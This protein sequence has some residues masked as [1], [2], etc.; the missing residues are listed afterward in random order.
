[1]TNSQC[2]V[3]DMMSRLGAME[4]KQGEGVVKDMKQGEREAVEKSTKLFLLSHQPQWRILE[5]LH[6][7]TLMSY[8]VHMVTNLRSYPSMHIEIP[9]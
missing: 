1:M 9:F 8:M 6:H 5:L 2:D 3:N 7:W 4:M